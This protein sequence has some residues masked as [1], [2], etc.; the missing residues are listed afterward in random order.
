MSG[1]SIKQLEIINALIE[2]GNGRRA[3]EQLGISPSTISGALKSVRR[4]TGKVLF[5]RSQ[6]ELIPDRDAL[7]LQKKYL[8]ITSLSDSRRRFVVTTYAPLELLICLYFNRVRDHKETFLHFIPGA[9]TDE[10]R[11]RQLTHREVD[12][13]IGSK[14][15][16]EKGIASVL[17]SQC[18]LCIMVS[19][20]HSS[21]KDI[22]TL[23][24]W[25]DNDHLRWLNDKQI[26]MEYLDGDVLT[27]ELFTQRRV[28]CE[29]ANLL[30]MTYIC[31]HSESIMLI[32]QIF[33]KQLM[34]QLPV[35][36]LALPDELAMTFS[37]Y[38]HYHHETGNHPNIQNFFEL[39]NQVSS[40]LNEPGLFTVD[41]S[42]QTKF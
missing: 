38:I 32:P 7:E 39:L 25:K 41:D 37:C 27:S 29:S 22:F 30:T 34:S 18:R 16:K 9:S 19:N 17:F 13:D 15:P 4:N 31:A 20:K 10:E 12:I 24:D 35:K 36:I 5:V 2:C 14:L 21:I 42:P 28:V 1:I 6:M 8:Q 3:S 26:A 11:I 23:K 33:A 40:S